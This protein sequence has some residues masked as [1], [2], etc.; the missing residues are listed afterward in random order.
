MAFSIGEQA[1]LLQGPVGQIESKLNIVDAPKCLVICCHPHSLHGGSMT[2]KVVHTLHRSFKDLSYHTLRFNFRGVGKSEGAFDE[3]L[4]EALD[5]HAL[6]RWAEHQFPNLP[7]ALAGFSFGAYVTLSVA[8]LFPLKFLVSIAPPVERFYFQDL[9]IP[10]CP[11]LVIQPMEDEVISANAVVDWY[12]SLSPTHST[13]IQ[14]PHSGHFF[15]SKLPELK[16]SI[17]T[18][19]HGLEI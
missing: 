12:Q 1:L 3:G 7:I 15:H 9:S 11:W 13:L 6:F 4:G 14:F 8:H 16:Q 10:S 19:L 2:N 5:V 18:G 17:E